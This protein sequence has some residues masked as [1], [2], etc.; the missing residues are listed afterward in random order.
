MILRQEGTCRGP[1]IASA[2]SVRPLRG[3]TDVKEESPGLRWLCWLLVSGEPR[4]ERRH[5]RTSM[6]HPWIGEGDLSDTLACN[7]RSIDGKANPPL[8]AEEMNGP[9]VHLR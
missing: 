2:T 4:S 8:E 9:R 6:T 5:P 7:R 3:P 1:S